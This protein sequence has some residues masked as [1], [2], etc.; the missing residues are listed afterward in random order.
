MGNGM[1]G[2]AVWGSP[3]P[4][5]GAVRSARGVTPRA[6][7]VHG[8]RSLCRQLCST[9]VLSGHRLGGSGRN[10][11]VPAGKQG[12]VLTWGTEMPSL[13]DG[14]SGHSAAP[15]APSGM[16]S[17]SWAELSVISMRAPRHLL[18]DMETSQII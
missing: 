6:C 14:C 13:A 7:S 11:R 4:C 10:N 3:S 2:Y 1:E 12:A 5:V 15:C 8:V 18:V 9:P 16:G 17:C